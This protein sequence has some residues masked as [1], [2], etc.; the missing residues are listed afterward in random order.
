MWKSILCQF[1]LQNI[2]IG[3]VFRKGPELLGI[4]S[5]V[6]VKEWNEETGKHYTIVFN[7]F[8]LLQIF[9]QINTRKLAHEPN[10]L[11]CLFNNPL[12]TLVLILALFLQFVIVEF[13]GKLLRTVSLTLEEHL[14]CWLLGSLSLFANFVQKTVLPSHLVIS[15]SGVEIGS[16]KL[17]WRRTVYHGEADA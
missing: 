1:L 9:N 15:F 10:V 13:G 14:I 12:F 11:R 3:T 7:V 4:P 2:V 16:L 6:G 17:Y 5:S 8:L